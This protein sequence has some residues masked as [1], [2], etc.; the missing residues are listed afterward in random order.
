MKTSVLPQARKLSID[1]IREHIVGV[2]EE[3]P[4]FDGTSRPYIFFD[5]AAST[6]PLKD[7]VDTVNRFMPWYS[8]V[9]RGSG[10][11][12]LVASQA[13]DDARQIVGEFFGANS[14]EHIVIFG[15]NTTE[16]IN[17]LSYRLQLSKQ[18]IVLIGMMEHHSNDLPWRQVAEVHRIKVDK[19][20]NLVEEDLDELLERHK[21]RVKLIAISGGSNVTGTLPDLSSIAR[22][23]HSNNAQILIDCAQLAP[24]RSVDMKSLSDPEHLDYITVSAHKMY[25]PFGTGALIGRRDT[26]EVGIPELCGGGTINV[27]TTDFIDW[28][29]PPDRDEAGSPNVVGAIAMAKALKILSA[30]TM[31]K[32]V[33]H[34]TIM[35][36]YALQELNK[37]EGVEIIGDNDPARADKRLGV[38]PFKIVGVPDG[39]VA[40][41]LSTEWGIGVRNGCFCAHPYVTQL[42]N[43]SD[44]EIVTFRDEV[45]A[46]DR[47]QIPGVVRVSFGMYN[48]TEEIDVL[49]SALKDIT[50]GKHKGQYRQNKSTGDYSAVGWE[51]NLSKYFTI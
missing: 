28:A 34:E 4:L 10:H 35:T 31:P 49:T 21:G 24:H 42:L 51:P 47:S 36:S 1:S 32:I 48:K 12:S 8:S 23:A 16:A 38:I 43:L 39:L 3:V 14:S 26:F 44:K 33:E 27:V 5:N 30:I 25:A 45:I 9:H 19:L 46:G 50:E 11:K 17:K 20:G 29:A 6:P 13:Y 41:I 37:I 15:K 22:K 40:A 7:V 2:D 18:D